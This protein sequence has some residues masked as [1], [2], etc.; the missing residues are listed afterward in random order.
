MNSPRVVQIWN[1]N[2]FFVKTYLD[3]D[4]HYY[5]VT[6]SPDFATREEAIRFNGEV[7]KF[8]RQYKSG[9]AKPE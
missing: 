9:D 6:T 2:N 7:M 5:T 8:A 4:G 1:G 3:T